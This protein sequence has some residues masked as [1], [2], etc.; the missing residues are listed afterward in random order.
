M[1]EN[2]VFSVLNAVNCNEH[3]EKKGKLSYLSWAWA[4]REVKACDDL[5][6]FQKGDQVHVTGRLRCRRYTDEAGIQQQRL[7][8]LANCLE[9]IEA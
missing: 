7:D 4:W 6:S 1:Q 9:R 3:V 2:S 5:S 8:I